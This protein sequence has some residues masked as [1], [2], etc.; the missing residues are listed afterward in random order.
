MQGQFSTGKKGLQVNVFL[1]KFTEDESGVTDGLILADWNW[2]HFT[3]AANGDISN[4]RW[5]FWQFS[6][7]QKTKIFRM[8]KEYFVLLYNLLT[9]NFF[10]P[11]RC[12][13]LAIWLP[14]TS[15]GLLIEANKID[16]WKD[17][18]YLAHYWI[19]KTFILK[20]ITLLISF[21][22]KKR[23]WKLLHVILSVF[24]YCEWNFQNFTVWEPESLFKKLSQ[25][26][27][28]L[29]KLCISHIQKNI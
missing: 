29:P 4:A 19:S 16:C 17:Q 13:V 18:Y 22:G 26:K 2:L 21:V 25:T 27:M 6:I 15:F 11:L 8:K 14:L 23:G 20:F 5:P 3:F 12:C 28:G 24:I 7:L 9:L 1:F 10:F